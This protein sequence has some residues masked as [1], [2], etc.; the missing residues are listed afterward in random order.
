ME[1]KVW[2]VTGA[3]KGIGLQIVLE[4]LKAG[5]IVVGTSR[6]AQKL[7][8]AVATELGETSKNFWAVEM[9]FDET[10]INTTVA[11]VIAKYGRID[12]LVNNAGYALLG[13]VEEVELTDV[14]KN[15]DV[16]FFG[17]LSMTQ[18]VLPQMRKQ[19]AGNI[20]NLASISGTVTGPTQGIYSAT[21]AGVIMLSE[22]LAAE[23]A[24]FGIKVT[25][26]APGGVRTD[27][28]DQTSLRE[29]AKTA[30]DYQVV[31]DTMAGLKRLNHNQ[32]G[33][34][35]RVAEAIVKVAQMKRPPVR[36]YLG[37]GAIQALQAKLNEV[38][39]EVNAHLDLSQSTDFRD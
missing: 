29:P 27:F 28:L 9:A 21:K 5:N 17:L 15:F 31:R 1:Q 39:A 2:L 26:I 25:A 12:V 7:S 8:Q 33:D 38:V 35:K 14:K 13:A 6:D 19:K 24:P 18:A 20:I 23:V 11:Q 3:S 37:S 4:A 34:P 36:L 10:S 16:N 32:S 30:S 22:A